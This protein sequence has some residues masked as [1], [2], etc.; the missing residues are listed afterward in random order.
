MKRRNGEAEISG[1]PAMKGRG[2]W[3]LVDQGAV[4][5]TNFLTIAIGA[6]LLALP[7]QAKLVYL[8]TAYIGLVVFNAAVIFSAAPM[9]RH[10]LDDTSPYL[11]QLLLIQ[12]WLAPVLSLLICL[13]FLGFGSALEWLP[14]SEELVW[15]A[16]FLLLQQLADFNRRADYVFGAV[17]AGALVSL[18][19]LSIRIVSLIVI[20]P[21]N[22]EVFFMLL[23][24]SSIPGAVAAMNRWC[25]SRGNGASGSY[26]SEHFR[27]ARW[28]IM[29]APLQWS[30]LHFPVFLVGL[31]AGGPAAAVLATV[32][33]LS[34]VANVLL[35]L[36]ETYVPVWML[37]KVSN[38]GES[39][40]HRSAQ[41]L[42]LVGA[43]AW[44]LFSVLIY[45]FGESILLFV[46]G[47][48]YSPYW[49]L[50]LILWIGNG[51]FFVGR[52]YGIRHRVVKRMTVEL[53]GSAGGFFVLL[54]AIPLVV[55]FDAYGGAWM[56]LLAQSG[57]IVTQILFNQRLAAKS[58]ARPHHE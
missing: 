30:C 13:L 1:H 20:Q 47:P 42:I 7:E 50:L 58:E 31:L 43:L 49:Q 51:L 3:S 55:E 32:R 4:S 37:S 27:L 38:G 12:G 15:A 6:Y 21:E 41:K 16:L 22:A 23:A 36:L 53:A 25:S 33:S 2:I 9:V 26:F 5:A 19:I 54:L 17:R 18:A 24:F 39:G 46:F 56:I 45:L 35:E 34:T 57:V 44:M 40:M 14:T 28:N 52:V 10:E 29:N 11:R 48:D 8:Y